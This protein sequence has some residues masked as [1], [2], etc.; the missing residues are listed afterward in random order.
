MLRVELVLNRPHQ[1]KAGHR[2][3][4]AGR[5]LYR[6][7]PGQHGHRPAGPRSVGPRSIGPRPARRRQ[8]LAQR[9]HEPGGGGVVVRGR[10]QAAVGIQAGVDQARA[11]RPGDREPDSRLRPGGPAARSARRPAPPPRTTRRSPFP[12]AAAVPIRPE[13]CRIC[14]PGN[15]AHRTSAALRTAARPSAGPARPPRTWFPPAAPPT[16]V[17]GLACGEMS[18][19]TADGTRAEPAAAATAPATSPPAGRTPPSGRPPR[20]AADAAGTLPR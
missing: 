5:G 11:G 10:V 6:L 19:C 12:P 20:R 14:S 18:S 7:R 2:A 13:A 1:V 9:G 17:T 3:V 8:P 4:G 15:P 16:R